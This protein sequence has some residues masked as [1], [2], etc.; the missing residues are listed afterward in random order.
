MLGVLWKRWEYI[1]EKFKG[2]DW[3]LATGCVLVLVVATLCRE[4]E[5]IP[6]WSGARMDGLIAISIAGMVI[7]CRKLNIMN[8]ALAYCGKYSM[9]VYLMH[10]F[11]I[12]YW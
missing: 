12:G 4:L 8:I 2:N 9:N 11:F 10:T 6:H 7:A 3:L 1:G 5:I